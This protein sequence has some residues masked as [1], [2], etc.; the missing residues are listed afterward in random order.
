[1]ASSHDKSEFS[2]TVNT[3]VKSDDAEQPLTPS[4]RRSGRGDTPD[5]AH[6]NK[7]GVALPDTSVSDVCEH[8]VMG[9]VR[10]DDDDDDDDED[11]TVVASVRVMS[12]LSIESR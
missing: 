5:A 6:G 9:F 2:H 8:A 12:V 11:N 4:G 10:K 7:E 1:M 3:L